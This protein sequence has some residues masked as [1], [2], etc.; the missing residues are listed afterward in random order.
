MFM[1]C[2]ILEFSVIISLSTLPSCSLPLTFW[3]STEISCYHLTSAW[4]SVNF[5]SM[6][7]LCCSDSVIS[8][9]LSLSARMLSSVSSTLLVRSSNEFLKFSAMVLFNSKMSAGF[10]Y[11]FYFFIDTLKNCYKLFVTSHRSIY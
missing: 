6:F 11:I 9:V 4:G 7:S 2:L 5:F 10:L 3:D 1:C 8:I